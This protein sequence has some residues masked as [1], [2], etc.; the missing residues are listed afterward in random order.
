MEELVKATQTAG[1]LESDLRDLWRRL[2]K[3]IPP[4]PLVN[5]RAAMIVMT[6]LLEWVRR[7]QGTLAQLAGY[8]GN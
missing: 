5:D 1:L 6:D 7:I 3:A 2:E 8:T 4:V